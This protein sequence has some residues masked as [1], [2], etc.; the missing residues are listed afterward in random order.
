[1]A[2]QCTIHAYAQVPGLPY[3]WFPG[4]P[5]ALG[6]NRNFFYLPFQELS[7]FVLTSLFHL[8]PTIKAL[9]FTNSLRTGH[10]FLYGLN[11]R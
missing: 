8:C 10:A 9:I 1:M 2:F 4:E 5:D 6:F 7:L 11:L 3:S